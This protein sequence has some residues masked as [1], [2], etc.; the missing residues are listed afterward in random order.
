VRLKQR[1]NDFRV[2][3]TL[4]EGYL[5][6]RGPHRVYRVTKIKH[7]SLEAA[8]QLGSMAGVPHGDVAMAGLKDRQG[9]TRQYMSIYHG[10]DVKFKDADLGIESVGFAENELSSRESLGNRFEI[11]VR[12]LTER[13]EK[14]LRASL[15]SVREHG[16]PSYFDEQRFGNLR[17]RQG[18]IAREL[19]DGRPESALKK[20]L[21]AIS[22]FDDR[23]A[24]AF[25]SALF[26]HWGDWQSCRDIAGRFGAH[27]SVFEHLRRSID[28]FPGAFRHI[29]TRLKLIHLYAWQSHLWNRAVNLY[30]EH[31]AD[32]QERFTHRTL[33]GKLLFPKGAIPIPES[34]GGSLPLVGPMLAGVNLPDQRALYEEVLAEEGLDPAR[35][36]IEGVSGFALKPEDRQIVVRPENLR[37]RPADRDPLNGPRRMV[38]L[39]FQLPRG[40]YATLVVRR[41]VGPLGAL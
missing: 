33:E 7:T 2:E 35:L 24:K 14:R 38:K 20:L 22:P 10:R 16:L 18:W 25:K 34:W 40:T 28:D 19:V 5:Q 8:Q 9:V 6:A 30:L 23:R 11:L 41:L 1:P 21:T 4:R 31:Y 3:E 36:T 12:D 15:P 32:P 29:A 17:H 13:E 37:A 27:H 26:R 39:S